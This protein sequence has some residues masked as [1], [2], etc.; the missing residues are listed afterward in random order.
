M[1]VEGEWS[2]LCWFLCNKWA[3]G[4]KGV[5]VTLSLQGTWWWGE[6]WGS[7]RG[8]LACIFP[9]Q[10]PWLTDLEPL[11]KD[12]KGGEN[13]LNVTNVKLQL[14]FRFNNIPYLHSLECEGFI[15]NT[16]VLSPFGR[17]RDDVLGQ[18]WCS[19]DRYLTLI[20]AALTSP[21]WLLFVYIFCT[22]IIL[23]VCVF[24]RRIWGGKKPTSLLNKTYF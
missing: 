4:V 23:E 7:H 20:I 3:L 17:L 11:I 14:V 5:N 10:L 18:M 12:T 1:F 8:N 9:W 21:V 16:A 19:G 13:L 24:D 22:K 15:R 2:Q 6:L